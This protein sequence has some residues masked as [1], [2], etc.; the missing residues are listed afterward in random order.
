MPSYRVEFTRSAEKEFKRLSVRMQ[1]TTV[2][3]LQVLSQ[4]PYS[5]LLNIKKLKGAEDLYRIRLGDHRIV[6]EMQNDRLV[7][8]V[9]KLA[10]RSKIY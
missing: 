10:H 7:I 2:E 3:A 5:E 8:L 4:N 1:S 9:I 6:Y